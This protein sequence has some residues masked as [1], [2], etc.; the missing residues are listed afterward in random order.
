MKVISAALSICLSLSCLSQINDLKRASDAGQRKVLG[1]G[2]DRRKRMDFTQF[3]NPFVG[4][5]GHGHTYPGP[6]L[7]FGMIQLGPDTRYN[8]WDGCSGYHY[9]DSVI[10]GF[11]HTHLSGTGVEDL[12]D[13]LIVPQQGKCITVPGYLNKKGY[14]SR[15]SH[16]DEVAKPGYYAVKLV[17]DNIDVRLSASERAGIHEYT[18]HKKKG[19][20]YILIDLDHRDKLLAAD[21]KVLDNKS[22]NG[23]RRSDSWAK[24][25]E[26]YFHLECNI[27]FLKAELKGKNKLV[28]SF[29]AT[30]EK[31][32]VKVGISAV[33]S[34]G[35]KKNLFE[36]IPN[37]DL[38]EIRGLAREKWNTELGKIHF[39]SGN[40]EVMANFY[41][42]LYHSYICPSLFSDVDGR[43]R[44]NDGQIHQSLTNKRYTTFSIWDTYRAAHP[45]FTITQQKRTLDFIESFLGIYRETGELPIWELWGNETDCMIGYHATSV[46]NDAYQKGI[47]DF[48]H[49]LALEAMLKS[50]Q[51]NELGKMIYA[52]QEF[53]SSHLEPESVSKNLEYAYDDWNISRFAI[54]LQR[55]DIA[56]EYRKRSFNYLNL[57][58]PE[59][60]FMQPRRSGIWVPGFVP[61]EVNFN[62]TEANSWQYSLY[63]PQDISGLRY[64]LGG[65]DSLATWLD[66]LFTATSKLD[67]RQQADIT[68]LIGQYAHGNEPSHH[69]AYLYNYTNE[70]YKTQEKVDRIL[71]EMY[72]NAPDGLSGNEDCGQMSAWYVFSALGFYPVCPGSTTYQF[73]RPLHDFAG[74]YLENGN[75]LYV[76]AGNNSPENKY[77]QRITLNGEMYRKNYIDHSDIMQGGELVFEMGA[78]P[79]PDL[80]NY[81]SDISDKTT[82]PFEFDIIPVPY[83]TAKSEIFTDSITTEIR[84]LNFPDTEIKYTIDGTEPSWRSRTYSSA[85]T[86]HQTTTLKAKAFRKKP[87]LNPAL[88]ENEK[89]AVS[90][91]FQ[92]I[93][94]N[95]TLKLNSTYDNQYS[96]GG[97]NALI[98]G[99]RG[100][101]DFRSGAWQGYQGI[102]VSGELVFEKPRQL[103][104]LVFSC[105]QDIK[106]WIFMPTE[107][108]VSYSLDG[109]TFVDLKTQHFDLSEKDFGQFIRTLSF[110]F[111]NQQVKQVRFVVKNR[112]VCPKGHL[113][114][115]EKSWLFLD[116]IEIK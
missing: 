69:M 35:A 91:T 80:R 26:F 25:Q 89:Q 19:K 37:F 112:G 113:G 41:T 101:E 87:G 75:T 13:L 99:L 30:T 54:A 94:K 116:E 61:S 23:H 46:I 1:D 59:S 106:S 76:R 72:H 8:G 16:K 9:S 114:E 10:Y 96:A 81:A 18:F 109:K 14:G 85:L 50:A 97:A 27:P 34:E 4:T 17:K 48:D 38:D 64:L 86:F 62:F 31:I 93:D 55:Q 82:I 102:D 58:N 53:L 74:I 43:Y 56:E 92:K 108:Q 103:N 110:D 42:S 105:L 115:G 49:K 95:T 66:R 22:V 12:C 6:V 45:L 2:P 44:G 73:G 98:D 7:P 40:E 52:N 36:E 111:G 51:K 79:N 3:V 39:S 90:C 24:K 100:G 65:K 20:K 21:I 32:L 88:I 15:F 11:S 33:D 78:T 28:L 29:P 60:K 83:F 63:V 71:K 68:G 47:T 104:Q 5:G 107:I 84:S 57:Y 67:G 70:P 77:I